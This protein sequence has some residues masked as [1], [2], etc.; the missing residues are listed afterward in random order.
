M[1]NEL[2]YQAKIHAISDIQRKEK[3]KFL[4][5]PQFFYFL[6]FYEKQYKHAIK[7]NNHKTSM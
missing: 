3:I 7:V 2:R 6:F 1:L 5:L 4:Q